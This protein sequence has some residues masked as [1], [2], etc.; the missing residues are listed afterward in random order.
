MIV[1]EPDGWSM[2]G[3]P[4]PKVQRHLAAIFA[5]DAEGYSRLMGVDEVGTLQTLTAHREIMDRL[6]K[7]HGGRIAN[8]AGDSVLA[9]F[10]SVVDAVQAAVDVQEALGAANEALPQD[11]RVRF[12]I[13]VHVGDV[14]VR[15]GDLFG[16]GVN[17]AARLQAIAA[18]GGVCISG[19]AH[20]YAHKSLTFTYVDLGTQSVKNIAEPVQAYAVRPS[21]QEAKH[22]GQVA[23]EDVSKPLALPDRPSIAVL[24]FANMS[25]DPEQEYFADGV[26]EDILTALARFPRLFVI[27]RNSSFIY[28]GRAVDV[29]QVAR[30]LGVRYVLEG[31]IRRAGSRVR[32]TGQLI[33]ADTGAHLWAD[34]FDGELTDIFTLQD[35]ITE[36]VVGAIEPRL[37][38]AE[39]E[40]AARKR[41]SSLTA[42][43]L[44]LRALPRYHS[45]TRE[46][47]E[48]AL[49]L[50]GRALELEP[51]YC[52]AAALIAVAKVYG[53]AQGWIS[54]TSEEM[55]EALR[56]AKLALAIDPNDPDALSIAGRC[57]AYFGAD[58]GTAIE[59]SQRAIRL[60]PNSA[61][62]WSQCG[63][64]CVYAA[65][66]TEAVE[67][68]RRAMRL[69]PL[70][71]TLYQSM[72]GLAVAFIQ[73]ERYEEAVEVARMS[74]HQNPYFSS[75]LRCLAAAHAHSGQLE[76]A[77]EAAEHL[78]RIE[79]NFTI[80]DWDRRSRWKHPAK[81][82]YIA[83]MR[84]A[85]LPE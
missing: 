24:P 45:M 80:S 64:A 43:D 52:A 72:T 15:G 33:H 27:A 47:F 84:L 13:G 59:L 2:S 35:E 51:N 4:G 50:L 79:P 6:I 76:E 20:H 48:E 85:G 21:E 8:T 56:F 83:G 41:P 18:P 31:S 57:M 63:S 7:E 25:G 22:H 3:A 28:K 53:T 16:D 42:Y 23:P 14:M 34:R 49:R 1:D 58:Y 54:N 40:M 68:Y 67:A 30:E 62:A 26:V 10:P 44:Y 32:I 77:R 78:L 37:V 39:V 17:V 61:A 9:E 71:L 36:Q 69:S 65:R 38:R 11:H 55:K 60:C 73:L 12:R 82:N 5:A 19:D 75:T 81:I 70:D 46:G 66:P 74:A 29:K